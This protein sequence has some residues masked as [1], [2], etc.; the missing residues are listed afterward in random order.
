M[1]LHL[2]GNVVWP[3]LFLEHR[4]LAWWIIGIGLVV[5]L[6]FVRF[7]TSWTWLRSLGADA[8]MN[9]A[10]ALLGVF[11][12][13]LAGLG[14][15]LFPAPLFEAHARLGTFNP[16][17]WCA[18]FAIAVIINAILETCVLRFGFK[19]RNWKKLLLGL[20]VANSLTV[21][22]AFYSVLHDPPRP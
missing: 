21:G 12:V 13:P 1:N 15:E 11:L 4:L 22:I 9:A 5:E 3:A 7:L 8:A 2:V 14:W 17:T 20:C 16:V 18:T 6:F 19:Q 10:S